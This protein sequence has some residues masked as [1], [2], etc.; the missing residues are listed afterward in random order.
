VIEDDIHIIKEWD[1]RTAEDIY[2]I[3]IGNY[4][5]KVNVPFLHSFDRDSLGRVAIHTITDIQLSK[6]YPCKKIQSIEDTC[7]SKIEG[8]REMSKKIGYQKSKD[9][10]NIV[11]IHIHLESIRKSFR[12]GH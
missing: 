10:L 1:F 4:N 11:I 3:K 12:K 8:F 7:Y 2:Y 6:N 9:V 5:A